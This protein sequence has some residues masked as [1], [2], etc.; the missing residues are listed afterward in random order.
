M[1]NARQS[2]SSHVNARFIFAREMVVPVDDGR[3]DASA[4]E[5][6]WTSSRVGAGP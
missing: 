4:R 5:R 3:D 2:L 6:A 1:S